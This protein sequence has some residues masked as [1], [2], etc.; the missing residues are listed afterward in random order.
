M[1]GLPSGLIGGVDE[2]KS[3]SLTEF[4]GDDVEGP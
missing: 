4:D 2:V 1:D 3:E